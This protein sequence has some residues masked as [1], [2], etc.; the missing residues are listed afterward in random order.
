[1]LSLNVYAHV[2]LMRRC[3]STLCI[4]YIML[5]HRS[6]ASLRSAFAGSPPSPFVLLQSP[7]LLFLL[8]H[9]TCLCGME[10]FHGGLD[11]SNSK[12]DLAA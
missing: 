3:C 1:M 9:M 7:A 5:P 8:P 4:S 6:V 2:L 12:M 10:D 11:V